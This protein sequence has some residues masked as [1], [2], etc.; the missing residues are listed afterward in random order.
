MRRYCTYPQ[1]LPSAGTGSTAIRGYELIR[2]FSFPYFFRRINASL[3]ANL[4]SRRSAIFFPD[5]VIPTPSC[6]I[7]STGCH[8]SEPR[9]T[10]CHCDESIIPLP[11]P[12]PLCYV[13]ILSSPGVRR[14]SCKLFKKFSYDC[15]YFFNSIGIYINFVSFFFLCLQILSYTIY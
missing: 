7:I 15:D 12:F 10:L 3:C 6:H 2:I 5:F 14:V 9:Y 13:Y 4:P 8:L 1:A 11:R